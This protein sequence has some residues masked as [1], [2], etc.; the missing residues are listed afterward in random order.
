MKIE[1]TTYVLRVNPPVE[2][3]LVSSEGLAPLPVPGLEERFKA[4]ME[5]GPVAVSRETQ[6]A[7]SAPVAAAVPGEIQA[8]P[9]ATSEVSA[10]SARTEAIVQTVEEIVETIVGKI[11]VTLSLAQGDGEIKIVLRPAV[12][13]GSTIDISAKG[14]ELTV[15]IAPA[16]P[17]AQRVIA[18]ALPQLE[19]ALASHAPA[20]RRVS[21]ALS[22]AK[23]GKFDETV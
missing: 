2:V 1:A 6:V 21:V 20:F 5:K 23:K 11:S 13:D 17:A 10:A 22:G 16:T 19:A 4:A 7:A 18:D 8:A 9:L 14:G 12:L 3:K 15:A